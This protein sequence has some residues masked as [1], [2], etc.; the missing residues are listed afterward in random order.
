M[1]GVLKGRLMQGE[2]RWFEKCAPLPRIRVLQK[3]SGF[4][5][6][7]IRGR[8]RTPTRR[9]DPACAGPPFG[10]RSRVIEMRAGDPA[11]HAGL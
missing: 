3:V 4:G 6:A 9:A 2:V 7:R 8:V 1:S 10:R 5:R 11:F